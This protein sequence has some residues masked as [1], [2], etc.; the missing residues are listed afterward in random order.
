MHFRFLARWEEI[1]K[2][3]SV[4]RRSNADCVLLVVVEAIVDVLWC[5]GLERNFVSYENLRATFED[6][7][8]LSLFR[9][10]LSVTVPGVT[11]LY[12]R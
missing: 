3:S 9:G 8:T 4:G 12:S 5:G 1:W 6:T 2:R 11:R 7:E 10:H